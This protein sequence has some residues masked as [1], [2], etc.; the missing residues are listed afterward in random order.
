MVLVS[1]YAAV[2]IVVTEIITKC[3]NGI[4]SLKKGIKQHN[5]KTSH[6]SLK[7]INTTGDH[8][9]TVPLPYHIIKPTQTELDSLMKT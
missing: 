8:Q 3:L 6:N 1:I 9:T 4:K 2:A 7:N 5:N